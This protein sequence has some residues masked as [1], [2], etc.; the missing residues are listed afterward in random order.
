M[1]TSRHSDDPSHVFENLHN[2]VVLV[3]SMNHML[4][5]D[6]GDQPVTRHQIHTLHL[7]HPSEIGYLGLP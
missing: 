4:L 5:R 3:H 6:L 7:E 2:N 1:L